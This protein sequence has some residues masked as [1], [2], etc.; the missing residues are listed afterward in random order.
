MNQIYALYKLFDDSECQRQRISELLNQT[1]IANDALQN[2]NQEVETQVQLTKFTTTYYQNQ[3]EMLTE[4][5]NQIANFKMMEDK[6]SKYVRKMEENVENL[7]K[8]N[9]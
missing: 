9:V 2:K 6:Y 5:M 4:G 1:R 7:K 3:M 8:E